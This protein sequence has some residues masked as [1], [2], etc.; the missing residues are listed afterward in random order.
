MNSAFSV[1]E[2]NGPAEPV[3]ALS[4]SL[5]CCTISVKVNVTDGT[6]KGK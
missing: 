1:S 3:L 4:R 6:A 2:I 5:N